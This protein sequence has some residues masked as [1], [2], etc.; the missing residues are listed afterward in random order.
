MFVSFIKTGAFACFNEMNA[1]R[2]YVMICEICKVN[3]IQYVNHLIIKQDINLHNMFISLFALSL[4]SGASS[5]LKNVIARVL[6]GR[7]EISILLTLVV[8]PVVNTWMENIKFRV[9]GCF[10][11][12]ESINY[13]NPNYRNRLERMIFSF[14]IGLCSKIHPI[15][16]LMDFNIPGFLDR[17]KC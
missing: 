9:Y 8:V 4:V 7:L 15:N 14:A 13:W 12:K 6:N 1:S 3:N 11:T 5:K 2:V 10:M 16:F 17:I